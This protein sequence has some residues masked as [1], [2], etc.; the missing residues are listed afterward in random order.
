MIQSAPSV[1]GIL[2]FFNFY[3]KELTA[4]PQDP[5]SGSCCKNS[6]PK[7]SSSKQAWKSSLDRI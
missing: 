5:Y 6:N 4:I 3:L 1:P 2:D 7:K